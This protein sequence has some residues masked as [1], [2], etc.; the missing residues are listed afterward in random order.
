MHANVSN[1][2]YC[3]CLRVVFESN[4]DL[5]ENSVSLEYQDEENRSDD[6]S[7]SDYADHEYDQH[8]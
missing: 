4:S 6:S 5:F 7:D 1:L 3:V 2:A 8:G